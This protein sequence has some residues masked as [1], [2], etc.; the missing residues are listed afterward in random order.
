ME[1]N[2]NYDSK[3]DTLEHIKRVNELLIKFCKELMDRAIYHDDSKLR[4]PEKADFDRLTPILKTLQYGSPEY[5]A[6]VGELQGA[7]RHHYDHNPHHPEYHSDGI[8][9]MDLLDLV[10][11]FMDWKAASQRT[12]D[13]NLS[14]SIEINKTRFDMS[15]Q[16]VSIF[17]NSVKTHYGW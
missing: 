7:L 9:G 15:D 1:I 16:L 17:M 8:N 10:E 13:G 12:K 4:E 3:A 14:K 2:T 11:M 6:S 5:K